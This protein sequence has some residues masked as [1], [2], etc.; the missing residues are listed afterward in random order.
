MMKS[1]LTFCI[2][3]LMD[4]VEFGW[5][6]EWKFLQ[7]SKIIRTFVTKCA[8]NIKNTIYFLHNTLLSVYSARTLRKNV[9]NTKKFDEFED[10]T[11]ISS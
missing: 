5:H 7:F 6:F 9:H 2:L 10:P 8:F 1:A 4:D 3:S 11:L